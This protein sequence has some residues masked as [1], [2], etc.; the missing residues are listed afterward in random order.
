M[1]PDYE[2]RALKISLWVGYFSDFY[3][4]R[5]SADNKNFRIK[6]FRIS[7]INFYIY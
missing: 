7:L 2:P 1:I 6:F 4:F 5:Y 3:L